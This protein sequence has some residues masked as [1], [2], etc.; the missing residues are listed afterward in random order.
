[1]YSSVRFGGRWNFDLSLRS[2]IFCNF[3]SKNSAPPDNKTIHVRVDVV[4]I[5]ES[6]ARGQI[7]LE[8]GIRLGPIGSLSA[9][10]REN[11][12]VRRQFRRRTAEYCSATRLKLIVNHEFTTSI[13][14]VYY[15]LPRRSRNAFSFS[16]SALGVY[17]HH[18]IHITS[19]NIN[20]VLYSRTRTFTVDY[21]KMSFFRRD[22]KI[23]A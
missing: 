12:S 22:K 3:F 18:K 4:R 21:V 14:M 11:Y 13:N 16:W 9:F 17:V 23:I 5:H 6:N 7:H 10:Y 20:M 8:N 19:N 2:R 15:A 1:M